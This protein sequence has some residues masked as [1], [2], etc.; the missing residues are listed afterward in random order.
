MTAALHPYHIERQMLTSYQEYTR[1]FADGRDDV[2]A[3]EAL[4]ACVLDRMTEG[5]GNFLLAADGSRGVVCRAEQRFG[6]ARIIE[7]TE[8]ET[9]SL[10]SDPLW[11]EQIYC[12]PA[13]DA[14]YDH[15]PLS[16]NDASTFAVLNS[17]LA[18]A[19][20][21]AGVESGCCV[22]VLLTPEAMPLLHAARVVSGA[23]PEAVA[24]GEEPRRLAPSCVLFDSAPTLCAG[25]I[26][27]AT[28]GRE[29]DVVIPTAA[30][31]AEIY[32]GGVPAKRARYRATVDAMGNIAHDIVSASGSV[33]TVS[34]RPDIFRTIEQQPL[35]NI[36]E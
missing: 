9:P 23:A 7:I 33:R 22:A 26:F 25:P 18:H 28:F 13:Y 10:T 19:L 11:L 8:F 34:L 14:A 6:R 17:R 1:A 20:G 16:D 32:V 31:A 5:S 3:P 24:I 21:Q 27:E 4:L 12:R 29:F 35:S 30:D 36:K 15:L 2:F